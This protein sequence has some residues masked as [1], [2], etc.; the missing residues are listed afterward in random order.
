MID[1][2][3]ISDTLEGVD[4][5]R[6][7]ADLAADDFDNG[8]SAAALRRSFERSQLVA[9]A[10]DGERVVG[11]A[12]LL[13][14]GVCNAYLLDVWT[15]SSHRRRGIGRAMVEALSEAVPG[16]H[17]ALQTDDARQFY[18]ALGFRPQPEFMSRV[19]GS[20]LENDANHG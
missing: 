11:M 1:G 2:V 14:D 9:I 15:A 8:R 6:A 10:W 5:E 17:V 12:R 3:R 20:W 13:S 7:K 4:W 18:E 16:Q 19:S